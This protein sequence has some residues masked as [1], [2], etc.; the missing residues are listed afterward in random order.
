MAARFPVPSEGRLVQLIYE[1]YE[2]MPGPQHD[3]ITAVG[4]RLAQ[5]LPAIRASRVRAWPWWLIPLLMAGAVAAAWWAGEQL[6]DRAKLGVRD[7]EPAAEMRTRETMRQ[8]VHERD[9]PP[10]PATHGTQEQAD[11]ADKSPMIYR[12]EP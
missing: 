12:R 2:S 8:P 5:Q 9:L 3:R 4:I 11:R 7:I 6:A 10:S 1:A